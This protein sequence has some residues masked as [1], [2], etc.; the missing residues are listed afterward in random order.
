MYRGIM[1][2]IST[3]ILF[4][5]LAFSQTCFSQ[6]TFKN[7]NEGL[8]LLTEEIQEL[9]LFVDDIQRSPESPGRYSVDFDSIKR[10]LELLDIGI[11]SAIRQP[12]SAEK[13]SNESAQKLTGAYLK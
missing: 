4:G 8:T 6:V 13:L 1:K 5:F 2:S 3:L 7:Q 11:K 12:V 10:D 9:I